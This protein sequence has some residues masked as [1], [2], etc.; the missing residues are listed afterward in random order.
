MSDSGTS[1]F[2]EGLVL[3]SLKGATYEMLEDLGPG[4]HGERVLSAIQRTK[5][6]GVRRVILKA[7]PLADSNPV[8]K[9]ARKR[10]DE[11]IQLATFLRHPNIA[12]IHGMHK[13]KG[14]LFLITEAVDGFSLNTLLEVATAKGSAF[15][16]SFMLYVGA[17]IA[18]AL[19]HAHTCRTA[20]GA[21]LKIVHRA[22]APTR[23]RV[24]FDGQVKLTD[25][26]V[27]SARLPGQHT[28]RRPGARGEVYWAAPESLLGQPEDARS[29]LFTL[30]LVL[31]E[32]ATGKHLLSAYDLLLKELWTRVP[33][34]ATEQLSSAIARMKNATGGID[35]EETIL[36]A[37]TFTPADVEAA[38]Q[39]LS[40]PTR[41][42]FRKLLRR[43]PDERHMSA[44]TLQD[45]LTRVLRA[46]GNYTARMAS[47][48]IQSA[49]RGAGQAMA[50][51]EVG[52]KLLR[53]QDFITT[54][55]SP[56]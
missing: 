19:A 5:N 55:P 15:P 32:F 35:P 53:H 23:I 18:G 56:V 30:G 20:E 45:D 47:Q 10:L 17:K 40:E 25:F 41:A 44:L 36:R 14:T 4:H 51:D 34:E 11:E 12:C 29:D 54:E 38:T 22:I 39:A 16:E 21:P 46:R 3:F 28:T 52:P 48:E 31:L 49:L 7:L 27:A 6:Q 2:P 8:L 1:L 37:A 24:T 13:A 43:N 9:A 50:E 26:G 33:E 42:V